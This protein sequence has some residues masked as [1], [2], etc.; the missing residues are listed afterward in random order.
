MYGESR[1]VY[2]IWLGN[3][4]E[5]DHLKDTGI[6]RRIIL[7]WI[8]GKWGGGMDWID[9]VQNRDGW[10]ALMHAVMNLRVP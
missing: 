10:R 9:L 7:R 6:D 1:G 5:R 8:F 4:R 3:L 2:R